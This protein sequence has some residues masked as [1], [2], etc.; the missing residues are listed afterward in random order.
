M[1]SNRVRLVGAASVFVLAA[2]CGDDGGKSA[3]P[4]DGDYTPA[5]AN[6]ARDYLASLDRQAMSFDEVMRRFDVDANGVVDAG[7][8]AALQRCVDA[9][10]IVERRETVSTS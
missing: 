4:A 6:A 2:A 9:K 1:R 8:L 5:A 7:D 3:P 10:A